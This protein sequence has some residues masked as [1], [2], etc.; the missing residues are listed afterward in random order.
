M[1]GRCR[2]RSPP[3][4]IRVEP[5]IT[6]NRMPMD[7]DLKNL[8]ADCWRLLMA[9]P[10]DRDSPFRTPVLASGAA[11]ARTVVLRTAD[12]AARTLTVFT[13]F[14]SAKADQLAADPR[15][16]LVFHDPKRGIQ[17]RAWGEAVL[18][19]RD[20]VARAHWEA[21]PEV[22]R[23]PY[24]YMPGPGT[25]L[26]RPGPVVPEA[27]DS[28]AGYANFMVAVIT[29]RR[30]EW[31][32]LARAGNLAARFEWDASGGGLSATWIVP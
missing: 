30:L 25:P 21:A 6:V 14:R 2:F 15:A 3:G 16:C 5:P 26:D 27:T 8:A 4:P 9:A 32:R 20:T 10:A 29:L 11:Q 13:D 18:H 24:V 1:A 7:P 17:L 28:E 23:A 31:L 19:A 22:T 12:E